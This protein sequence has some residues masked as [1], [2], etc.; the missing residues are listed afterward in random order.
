MDSI[1]TVTSSLNSTRESS[2]EITKTIQNVQKDVKDVAVEQDKQR[3]RHQRELEE[4]DSLLIYKA[5]QEY[6]RLNNILKKEEQAEKEFT[7]KHGA[8]EWA[9]VVQLKIE[10]EKEEKEF[11][12]A[13]DSDL[14]KSRRLMFWCIFAAC[15]VTYFLYINKMI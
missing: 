9:K 2:K 12:K 14:G 6:E 8:K 11:K 7:A 15:W 1:T 4:K 3:R 13:F 10:V 5:I